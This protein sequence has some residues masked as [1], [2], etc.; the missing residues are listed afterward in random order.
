VTSIGEGAFEKCIVLS[1]ARIENAIPPTLGKSAFDSCNA[2]LIKVPSS[3]VNTYKAAA[4]WSTYAAKI[5]GY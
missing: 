1:I 2:V 4:G 5:S 3:V